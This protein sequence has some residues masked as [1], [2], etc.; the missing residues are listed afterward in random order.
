MAIALKVEFRR[1]ME[2]HAA[3]I[4]GGSRL[5]TTGC[6]PVELAEAGPA[7]GAP[8]LIV[9]GSGGGFDQGLL[10]G[11]DYA[12]RGFRVIAPSRPG[13]LRTPFP[14]DGEALACARPT[15]WPA[16]WTR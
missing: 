4:A 8:L 10:I 15:C 16:C 11:A 9:H 1:D 13:Y 14:A 12:G 5:M 2:R 3:R 7:N 6:G